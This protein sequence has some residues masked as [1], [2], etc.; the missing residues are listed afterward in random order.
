MGILRK[1]KNAL[2]F[3]LEQRLV[4]IEDVNVGF[5]AAKIFEKL[6]RSGT[7]AVLAEIVRQFFRIN[8]VFV[9]SNNKKVSAVLFCQSLTS[10]D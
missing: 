7:A 8:R 6:L 9:R 3:R 2:A 5:G 4:Q 10:F 1:K